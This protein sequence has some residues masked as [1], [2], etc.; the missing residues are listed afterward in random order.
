MMQNDITIKTINPFKTDF[1]FYYLYHNKRYLVEI[2]NGFVY[3]GKHW[4]EVKVYSDNHSD[5]DRV[6]DM[7]CEIQE[8]NDSKLIDK[9]NSIG[10]INP[11]SVEELKGAINKCRMI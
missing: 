1:N 10:H 3:V 6:L 4:K 7:L 11:I 9:I 5:F 8:E 2:K